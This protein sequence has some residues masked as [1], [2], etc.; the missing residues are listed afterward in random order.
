MP[1]TIRAAFVIARRDFTATVLSKTF[2][3]FLLGPLFPIAL[4]FAFGSIGAQVEKSAKLPAIVVIASPE[5]YAL[6]DAA[7]KRL[8]PLASELPLTG[9]RR[10]DPE[11]DVAA[12]RYRLLNSEEEPTLGVLDGGLGAP[13][14]TGADTADSRTVRQIRLYVDEARRMKVEQPVTG[15]PL[16]VTLTKTSSGA[17]AFAREITA[18][19]GQTILFVL[20][21]L[22]AGMLLSQLIEEKSSKVIE[23]LAAAVPVDAIFLG[24]LFAMLGM[25]LVGITVWAGAGALAIAIWTEG[26]LG[27][28][29]PPAVGWTAFLILVLVY[30]SMSYLLIGAT[31]LGIGAQASTVRE[32]QT[33]SMPVTMAQVVLFGFASLGVGNPMSAEAIGAAV[34]P[35]SS[36]FAM[37]GR[38]AE[39]SALWPHALAFV[40]QA[41]W[42][43]LILKMAAAIFR[44][45]VLKSGPSRGW[46]KFF[47]RAEPWRELNIPTP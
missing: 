7:R 35:L 47:R 6:L 18:R 24:K 20:T 28:L 14:F 25:S 40:W 11:P 31:F 33:L 22:L 1:E 4:G 12:Q 42:V 38:A 21:I 46:K 30:F 32:V 9:L 15:R 3:L 5:D 26:G 44:R 45:S 39:Q 27:S 41:L 2:L 37:I 10:A 23:V 36:P 29:P 8:S 34:F 16:Q 13:H 19:I 43:A 17:V